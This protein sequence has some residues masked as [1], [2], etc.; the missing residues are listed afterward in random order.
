[1][2]RLMKMIVIVGILAGSC[3]L[4]AGD[5]NKEYIN[6][7]TKSVQ[8]NLSTPLKKMFESQRVYFDIS[9]ED[10]CPYLVLSYKLD[11]NQQK[12]PTIGGFMM[13]DDK[14]VFLLKQS[15][16]YPIIAVLKKWNNNEQDA[17][18]I[19]DLDQ[20]VRFGRVRFKLDSVRIDAATAIYLQVK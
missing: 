2:M 16:Y 18:D 8:I 11:L 1:M 7:L 14:T 17:S 20:L 9:L 15:T 5:D 4:L 13:L 12:H 19:K 6:E 10:E 3:S